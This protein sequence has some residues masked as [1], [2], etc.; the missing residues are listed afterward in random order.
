MHSLQNSFKNKRIKRVLPVI[1]SLKF[2]PTGATILPPNSWQ[3]TAV[4]RFVV[5]QGSISKNSND[6]ASFASLSRANRS[7]KYANHEK[8]E[9]S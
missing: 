7:R 3:F 1:L 8:F 5:E 4:T 9:T 6:F 2:L